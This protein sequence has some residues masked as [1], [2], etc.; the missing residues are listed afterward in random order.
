[1]Q[2]LYTRLF[3]HSPSVLEATARLALWTTV[4]AILCALHVIVMDF[5]S[6]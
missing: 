5:R 2:L 1:M 6:L 4:R 3:L